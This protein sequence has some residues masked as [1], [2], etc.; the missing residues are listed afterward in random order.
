MIT[1]LI[2]LVILIA[3]WT[4][5]KLV[6]AGFDFIEFYEDIRENGVQILF[7]AP[8]IVFAVIVT[9]DQIL[10]LLR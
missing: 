3:A 7:V 6:I 1:Y 10:K 2:I 8:V 5:I 4:F 9:V